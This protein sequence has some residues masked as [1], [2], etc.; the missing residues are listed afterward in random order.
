M[1]RVIKMGDVAMKNPKKKYNYFDALVRLVDYN[2]KAAHMLH[3]ILNDYDYSKLEVQIKEMHDIE[4]AADLA[5]HEMM[6]HL[7]KEFIT[8]I[9]REDISQIAQEIDNVTD[10]IE[11]VLV[12]LY[13]FNIKTLRP[14][15]LEFSNIIVA[16]CE[17]LKKAMEDFHNF[18]RSKTVKENIIYI[19]DLEEV[20]DRMYYKVM[21]NL[22]A[23]TKDPIEIAVWS[24]T[25]DYLE[26]CCDACEEVADVMESIIM[27]NT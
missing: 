11:D 24:Q 4:H 20:G 10:T 6:N 14:E 15:A 3:S 12:R 2:C 23:N 18:R 25:F 26:K 22:H 27:K 1:E 17:A 19:N 7:L 9:E 13:M 5:K 16:C 8:P 21:H